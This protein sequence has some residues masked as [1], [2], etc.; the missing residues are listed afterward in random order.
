[1]RSAEHDRW[2][3]DSHVDPAR[4]HVHTAVRV[5]GLMDFHTLIVNTVGDWRVALAAAIELL[6]AIGIGLAIYR[7]MFGALRRLAANPERVIEASIDRHGRR[8]ARWV[9]PLLAVL[10][11]LPV[12]PLS[13]G[14]RAG[15]QHLV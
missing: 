2:S 7:V 12:V 5:Y 14:V 13:E 9:F 3:A 11:A 15:L 4:W 8:A 10:V 6:V 1:A